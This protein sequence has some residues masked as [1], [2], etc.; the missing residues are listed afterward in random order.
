VPARNK[1]KGL[2]IINKLLYLTNSICLLLLLFSYLSPYISPAFFWPIA[3]FGLLFPVFYIANILFLIYWV[4]GLKKQ[5][6]ANIIILLI[7]TQYISL[8]FGTQPKTIE[9]TDSIKVLSYNVHLFNRYGWIAKADIKSEIVAFLKTEKADI[10]CIQ[11]FYTP[12]EIPTLNYPHKHIGLQSKKNQWHMAIYSNFPQIN[13]ATVS[14]KGERMNNTCIYSDLSIDTD[15]IRVYN[16]HLAS[17]WFKNSDYSFLQNPKKETL[18]KG[19]KGIVERMKSSYKKRAEEAQVIKEHMQNSP[20]P[21]ILC[22]DFNDTPLSYAYNTIINDLND[23]FSESGK[24]IGRSFVK[25]PALRIDYILYDK[26]FSS[27]NYKQH[28]QELSD[29]YAISTE[30]AIP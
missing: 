11:E 8:F 21:I 18:K 22:G 27:F 7:G 24:G 9:N 6:W 28:K 14:I 4:I 23:S 15:T 25:I 1:M 26:K 2:S 29:H 10:L 17:N 30:L 19:I 16:I 20:F 12:D 3:F 5:L 13:K